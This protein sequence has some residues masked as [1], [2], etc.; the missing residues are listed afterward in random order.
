MALCDLFAM[1]SW[2]KCGLKTIN[3]FSMTFDDKITG[4]CNV[5]NETKHDETKQKV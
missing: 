1:H 2:K 3:I 4:P 5:R